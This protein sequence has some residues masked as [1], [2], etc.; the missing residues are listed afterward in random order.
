MSTK[1]IVAFCIGF[2]F[3]FFTLFFPEIGAVGLFGLSGAAITMIGI[4]IGAIIMWLFVD[5]G[6]PSILVL[7][8]LTQLPGL[9]IGTIMS[10]SLGNNTIAFLIFSC[11]L[12]YALSA[13]GLLRRVAL[14]FV[15]TP[16]AKKSPW[17]FAA[18]YFVSILLI[19]SFIAPTVL[20]VLFFALVKEIYEI[21]GL[22]KGN[23]YARMLM[24]GTAIMVSISCAM[25]PIAHTFPLMAL[26]FYESATGVAINWIDYM[27]VGIPSGLLAAGATF[28]ALWLGF[29]NKIGEIKVKASENLTK[30]SWKEIVALVVF[31]IVV[32]MWL[33]SGLFPAWIPILKTWTTTVPPILGIV[34]LCLVGV[35]NFNDAIKNG[36][37]WTA[38]ILC[39]ATLAVGKYLTAAEFGITEAIGALMGG[40]IGTPTMIGLIFAI[41]A[42]TIIMT[43][44]MSNIVTTTVAYNLLT[45]IVIATG[46]ISPVLST[47]L[48][49]ICA[50]MAY[51]TPPSIAHV[52]L[53][54]GSEYCDSKDMLIYGGIATVV[55]IVL[56]VLFGFAFGGIIV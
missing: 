10:V 49:G 16:I 43:N 41:V 39:S 53:A 54:A 55:S 3:L 22:D 7:F 6:W 34:V 17:A 9:A 56:V 31:L 8:A 52:A 23:D 51:A 30:I 47:I 14:W 5:V 50:S 38:I 18:M 32:V 35:L 20:F 33:V 12:T 27:I 44:L 19:G 24:I 1:K 15:N 28:G 36:V 40:V 25:T 46:V 2:F 13:T 45:P 37:P 42:F 21:N 48:I 29:K 26:G 4:F 11:I